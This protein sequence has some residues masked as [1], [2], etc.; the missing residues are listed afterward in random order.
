MMGGGC[1]GVAIIISMLV[2]LGWGFSLC[3]DPTWFERAFGFPASSSELSSFVFRAG[4]TMALS[5]CL[6][7]FAVVEC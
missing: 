2:D 7:V 3:F 6:A 5:L 4:K 1:D